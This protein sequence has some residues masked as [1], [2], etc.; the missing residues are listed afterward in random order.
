MQPRRRRQQSTIT[1]GNRS[2]SGVH[3]RGGVG[4][5]SNTQSPSTS[6]ASTRRQ[7]RGDTGSDVR[8]KRISDVGGSRRGTSDSTVATTWEGGR[9]AGSP[10]SS[11][12]SAVRN[13]VRDAPSR[14]Q[15]PHNPV[16][17]PSP[18]PASRKRFS[19]FRRTLE[20]LDIDKSRRAEEDR[21]HSVS[22]AR[23]DNHTSVR[24][25]PS[26]KVPYYSGYVDDEDRRK[27]GIPGRNGEEPET[28]LFN[29]VNIMVNMP[30]KPKLNQVV[31]K[32]LKILAIMT[33]SYFLLMALYFAA[34][35]QS[36]SHLHNISILVVDLDHAMI[37]NEF[38][39]FTQQDNLVSE[40][41]NWSIQTY[42]DID[43]VIRDV[44]NG[45]YWGAMVVKPNATVALNKAVTTPQPDYDPRKAFLFIYDGGRDPLAVKPYVVAS[46]YTQFLQFSSVFNPVWISFVL[47]VA[48]QNNTPVYSLATAP[49]TLGTPVAFEELDLHPPT[50]TI[51]TSA[52]S[53]AYIWIF[54]I[55]GGST[56][57]VANAVQ[58]IARY[59]SVQRTMTLLLLP[60]LAFL[61]A[62]S[63]TYTLLLLIFG[64]PFDSAGQFISLFLSMLLLQAAVASL[65]L[66]LIFLIPVTFIPLFTI[67]FVVMNVIAVFNP[68]ELMPRF[69][70][71]VYAMPFLNA[72]Q[73]ARFVL[74]GSYN[75]LVYNITI[76]LAWILVPITLLP[77]AITRQ[78]R[79][80]MEIMETEEFERR[81][82]RQ[83][84]YIYDKQ[85]G[86]RH[87]MDKDYDISWKYDGDKAGKRGK[88]SGEFDRR[89]PSRSR[90]YRNEGLNM[91]DQY[92]NSGDENSEPELKY[93]RQ[94]RRRNY[95]RRG[96]GV[97]EEEDN[98]DDYDDEYTDTDD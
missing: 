1:S 22:W 87:H 61:S 32:L 36:S 57:L 81:Q 65:V 95:D 86:H 96:N 93:R 27:T 6:H 28:N 56:Y 40:Q 50:A 4:S 18:P 67:T 83:K 30:S 7:Q 13:D 98:Y 90:H 88:Q 68:V 34:E 26:R 66:F 75:R 55:A 92:Y 84:G 51:I 11:A 89:R 91:N 71:W 5:S 58:P 12:R 48:E 49:Q 64:V 42:K 24:R 85:G 69:Y 14:R 41:V 54:L 35:Y 39:N 43:S 47:Q 37:G 20:Y 52:T 33:M 38:L 10:A 97:D 29:F 59:S 21:D 73:M 19:L 62:L 78:K 74:M 94:S 17:P 72:V 25:N 53:V 82:S 76:L 44:D 2:R 70:R 60:L 23:H 3:N 15:H 31:N 16:L 46:M 79:L 77:F 63:M 9:R 80:M 45:N 8:R